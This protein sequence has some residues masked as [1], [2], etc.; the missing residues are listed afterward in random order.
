MYNIQV[1]RKEAKMKVKKTKNTKKFKNLKRNPYQKRKHVLKRKIKKIKKV[2]I[3]TELGKDGLPKRPRG[4]PKK[5]TSLALNVSV[6]A[7]TI[8]GKK[9]GRPKKI[10]PTEYKKEEVVA[11]SKPMKTLKLA[12]YCPECKSMLVTEDIDNGV[13]TCYKCKKTGKESDLSKEAPKKDIPKSKKEYLQT[14]HSTTY[15]DVDHYHAPAKESDEKAMKEVEDTIE[16]V[17][18][19]TS[20]EE[21]A[22]SPVENVE[23]IEASDLED[24]EDI[25]ETEEHT[26]IKTDEDL[27]IEKKLKDFLDKDEE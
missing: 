21:N 8:T 12:G 23:S 4:R 9:R 27:T 19:A 1:K 20:V 15:D 6:N 3:S 26:I 24:I 11:P 22:S 17:E 2:K 7:S 25:V 10:I 16:E 13:F 14:V 18:E 5:S